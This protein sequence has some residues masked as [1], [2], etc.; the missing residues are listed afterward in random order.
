MQSANNFHS[1][2]VLDFSGRR[3]PVSP[4]SAAPN[5]AHGPWLCKITNPQMRSGGQCQLVSV[6]DRG[7]G[8]IAKIL[9][10]TLITCFHI[11]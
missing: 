2:Q 11:P 5:V 9:T 4:P 7:R 10:P 3:F 1:V 6:G 8:S